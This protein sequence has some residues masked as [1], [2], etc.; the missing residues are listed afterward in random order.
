MQQTGSAFGKKMSLP[1]LTALFFLL[2]WGTFASAASIPPYR[3]SGSI[4]GTTL[5]YDKLK[6]DNKGNVTVVISNPGK[7]GETFVANFNF[8]TNKGTYLTGFS[9]EGFAPRMSNTSYALIM[10]DYTSL[11][12]A[13]YMKTFGRSGR[14]SDN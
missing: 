3:T 8:Y 10:T 12:K 11:K 6:I 9:I 4:A 5:L 14:T 2:C 1:A 13:A 7:T